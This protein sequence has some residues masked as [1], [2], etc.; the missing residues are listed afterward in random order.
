[1]RTGRAEFTTRTFAETIIWKQFRVH[2]QACK[3]CRDAIA[4]AQRLNKE[5]QLGQ[6]TPCEEGIGFVTQLLLANSEQVAGEA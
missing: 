3:T 4:E 6:L 2:A 5:S 1:M